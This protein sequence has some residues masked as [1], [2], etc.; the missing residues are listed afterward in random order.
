[1]SRASSVAQALA[2]LTAAVVDT[3][4]LAAPAPDDSAAAARALE[5]CRERPLGR[6]ADP[7]RLEAWLERPALAR[8]DAPAADGRFPL[9]VYAPS[10]NSDPWE[11][12]VLI[13]HLASRGFVVAS[14]PSVGEDEA[15]VS[16]DA[17]GSH[18]QQDD[19]RFV[20]ARALDDPSVD[21]RRVGV[22]GFSWGGM[23]G[24]Q[25]ALRHA[26]VS[27]VV[28][29]DGAHAMPEYRPIA[30]SFPW[31]DPRR[32]RAACLENVPRGAGRDTSFTR[33][34]LYADT[35]RWEL[36]GIGHNDFAADMIARY[37]V[38]AADAGAVLFER[39]RLLKFGPA[40]GPERG[41]DLEKLLRLNLEVYPDSAPSHFW[42]AQVCLARDDAAAAVGE[43]EAA[44]RLDPGY[45]RAQRL[46]RQLTAADGR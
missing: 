18:A 2:W 46:L 12:S 34:S 45:E 44:L 38:A 30:A 25:L 3:H 14:A 29:L 33:D 42:L 1:M 40:W 22:I 13:E 16:A 23:N 21:P 9:V 11:N 5:S 26:G 43:L 28:S 31:W 7:A 24:M 17:A 20:L 10:I 41:G 39:D 35:Y 19:L 27:A 6:G 36:P 32:L 37:R 4:A 8:R 15:A